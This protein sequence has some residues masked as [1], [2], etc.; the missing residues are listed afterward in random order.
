MRILFFLIL[1]TSCSDNRLAELETSKQ[2]V[3]QKIRLLNEQRDKELKEKDPMKL[4][5]L[6]DGA[7]EGD[8][9]FRV[10]IRQQEKEYDALLET[11]D[12]KYTLYSEP[13]LRR[14]DS[15]DKLIRQI[16]P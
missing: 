16:K 13:L 8:S 14:L 10:Y 15:L 6:T 7:H 12:A 5:R 9:A 2:D 3:M 1:I 11:V 4:L